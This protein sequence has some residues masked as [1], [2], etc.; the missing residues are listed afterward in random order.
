M[1]QKHLLYHVNYQKLGFAI[2]AEKSQLERI[3]II[4]DDFVKMK[5]CLTENS[6]WVSSPCWTNKKER[7]DL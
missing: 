3:L 5:V 6:R 4:Y 7:N 1:Y 2:N